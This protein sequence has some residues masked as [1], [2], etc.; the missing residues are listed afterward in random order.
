MHVLP[1]KSTYIPNRKS[2][3]TQGPIP[4]FKVK[5][6]EGDYSLSPYFFYNN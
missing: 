6:G 4:G 2:G 5:H 3:F 1:E